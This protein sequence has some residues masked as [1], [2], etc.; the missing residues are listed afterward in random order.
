MANLYEIWLECW[1][2]IDFSA[3]QVIIQLGKNYSGFLFLQGNFDVPYEA[4]Q[5]PQ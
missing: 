5:L 1:Y 2:S 3:I 4:T